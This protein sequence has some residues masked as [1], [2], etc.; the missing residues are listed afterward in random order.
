M[1]FSWVILQNDNVAGVFQR[2]YP[3]ANLKLKFNFVYMNAY[4]FLSIDCHRFNFLI[5]RFTSWL[6]LGLKKPQDVLKISQTKIDVLLH[7]REE[8]VFLAAL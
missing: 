8:R 2:F 7:D 3:N 1:K 6:D 5:E 4:V